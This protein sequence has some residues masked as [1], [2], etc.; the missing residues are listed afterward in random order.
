MLECFPFKG[1]EQRL[2]NQIEFELSFWHCHKAWQ[3]CFN[4]NSGV[5]K[6]FKIHERKKRLVYQS[7]R[8][9]IARY[10]K[11]ENMFTSIIELQAATSFRMAE[12]KK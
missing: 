1:D 2:S 8:R 4:M 6:P 5:L 7:C 11:V 3:T 12:W 10:S 9:E